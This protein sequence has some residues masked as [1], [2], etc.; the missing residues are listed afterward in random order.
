MFVGR[1]KT[2][3][4]HS[5]VYLTKS[6]PSQ[7]IVRLDLSNNAISV[8]GA[9]ALY[10]FLTK[11]QTLKTFYLSNCGLGIMGSGHIARGL[12]DGKL[13]LEE[14]TIA[15]NR[16]EEEG[17]SNIAKAVEGMPSIRK[18]VVFQN[19]IRDIGM[20]KILASLANKE[21]LEHLD[22]NDNCI[23]GVSVSHLCTL[24]RTCPN[25]VALNV[26]DCNI[27][28]DSNPKIIEAIQ[29]SQIRLHSLGYNYNEL[30]EDPEVALK[31]LRVLLE[32]NPALKRLDIT[33]NDFN[34]KVRTVYE[35]AK[36]TNSSLRMTP[37]EDDDE[38]DDED[39]LVQKEALALGDFTKL[40][41]E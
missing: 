1:L 6:L 25:L 2:E 31:F 35:E 15:R 19:F 7:G 14:L 33:G 13:D 29:E 22:V 16:L 3:I 17:G 24:I 26:S 8:N 5:V 39:S 18:L 37:F 40:S 11:A 9:E 36:K 34:K 23:R 30:G 32:R 21:H 27:T 41:L 28:S 20:Q 38:D 12:L 4:P 10:G